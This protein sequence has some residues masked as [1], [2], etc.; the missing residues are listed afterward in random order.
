MIFH[1]SYIKLFIDI[2]FCLIDSISEVDLCMDTYSLD[3]YKLYVTMRSKSFDKYNYDGYVYS[4]KLGGRFLYSG[5]DDKP[6]SQEELL[7]K[8]YSIFGDYLRDKR[9]NSIIDGSV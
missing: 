9:I 4:I 8:F 1:E 2:G 6:T 5:V 7:M 3:G